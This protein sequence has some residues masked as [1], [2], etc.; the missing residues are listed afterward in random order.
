[1]ATVYSYYVLDL[2]HI[3][4]LNML[5]NAKAMAGPSGTLVVGILTDE[6]VIE[7]KPKPVLSFEERAELARA[8]RY[9]DLVVP[10]ETYSPLPNLIQIK[11]DIHMESSSHKE[12]DIESIRQFM[13]SIGGKVVVLPYWP[14]QSSTQI[15]N[16]IRT[17]CQN[18][19]PSVEVR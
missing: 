10:Q 19:L 6:A 1:M 5:K 11:P 2:V 7:R 18:F 12:E 15:K 8:I 17:N 16:K 3:G 14:Q 9:V 4:H 13:A